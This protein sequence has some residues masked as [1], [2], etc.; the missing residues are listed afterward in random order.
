MARVTK[1]DLQNQ[2]EN[3]NKRIERLILDKQ[4]YFVMMQNAQIEA[5]QLKE[6]LSGVEQLEHE[7]DELLR[8][9]DDLRA[10]LEATKD[11]LKEARSTARKN[12]HALNDLKQKY[13]TARSTVAMWRKLAADR[14]ARIEDLEARLTATDTGVH[15]VNPITEQ[16][17][18]PKRG[19]PARI[20]EDQ[21]QQIRDLRKSGASIRTIAAAAN[22]SVGTAAAILKDDTTG[23]T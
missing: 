17:R 1:E 10:E 21:R 20:T 14:D 12:E 4:D 15:K 19:R 9:V 18:N 6:Q 7:R 13:Q 22:V 3:M 2:I 23:D 11:K 8:E 5:A 16:P